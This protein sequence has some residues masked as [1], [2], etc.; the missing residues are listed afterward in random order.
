M[1]RSVEPRGSVNAPGVDIERGAILARMGEELRAAGPAARDAWPKIRATATGL[2]SLPYRSIVL[3]GC[4][5]SYYGAQALRALVEEAAGIP[6]LAL[7]AMEAATYP[8]LLLDERSLLVAISV[9]G[10][11]ERTIEAVANH[12]SRGGATSAI[13]AY[14]DSDVAAVADCAIATGLRGTPGPVPGTANFLGSMLGILGIAA[15]LAERAGR[16]ASW[17]REVETTLM[18]IDGI[19]AD[20]ERHARAV[21]ADMGLPL[22]SLGS[23]PDLGIAWYGVAKFIEAAAAFGVGQDLEEWA[24]EQYFTTGPETTVFIHATTSLSIPRAQR[25]AASV[26]KVGGRLVTIGPERLGLTGERHWATPPVPEALQPLVAW[27]PM[28]VAARTYAL[29]AGRS[30]FG[31]DTPNRMLTVDRDIYR[32]EPARV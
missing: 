24:H 26:L 6:V 22:C 28:A 3:T 18:R 29:Q 20:S 12:R 7:P 10:K 30:P 21:A 23:G 25:V 27:V 19:V 8:P 15:E 31:I 16:G 13:T 32:A 2:P 5:D 1:T 14:G 11:V 17:T 4:G 9:S